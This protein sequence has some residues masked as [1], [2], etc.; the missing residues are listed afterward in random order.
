MKPRPAR[1]REAL[2]SPRVAVGLVVV[3]VIAVVIVLFAIMHHNE[4][5]QRSLCTAGNPNCTMPQ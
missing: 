3:A 4:Q 5:Y 2:L 1:Y